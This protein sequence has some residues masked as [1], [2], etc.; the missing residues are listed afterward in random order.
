MIVVI[1]KVNPVT[2]GSGAIVHIPL[3]VPIGRRISEVVDIVVQ[4]LDVRIHLHS[5]MP[6]IR[7][8]H[9]ISVVG[10]VL[11]IGTQERKH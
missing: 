3:V 10:D 11:G 6:P 4:K 1:H 7:V 5:N 2:R 9:E 8:S